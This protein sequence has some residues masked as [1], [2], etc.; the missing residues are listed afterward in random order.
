M[1]DPPFMRPFL[2]LVLCALCA[3]LLS[4]PAMPVTAQD[5]TRAT[6]LAGTDRIGTA[7]DAAAAFWPYG[8]DA[9][10]VARDDA[11]PDA[12]AGG[13]LADALDAPLL[14]TSNDRLDP[15]V[16]AAIDR[17]DPD[18][19]FLLGGTAALDP[20]VDDALEGA[21]YDTTRLA[22]ADRYAT[23]VEIDDRINSA[24][25]DAVVA[26]GER[27]P[28]ALVAMNLLPTRILLA[29]TDR[30]TTYV[31]GYRYT[32]IGGEA[33]LGSGIADLTGGVRIAGDSRYETAAEVLDTALD[34]DEPGPLFLATGASA[35]DALAASAVVARTE[36]YLVIV[37]PDRGLV[38]EQVGT[39]VANANLFTGL[40]V[41]GGP[42]ALDDAVVAEVLDVL[43][44]V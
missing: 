7:I 39:L 10:I 12:L 42:V 24:D 21:G 6:R 14:L 4:V 1:H 38:D 31:P 23:A 17:L 30:F 44:G 29:R 5:A 20:S 25:D 40:Y 41:L 26:S 19:V 28:D 32:L 22:G 8:A 3:A 2:R 15:R 9:V 11:F 37:D 34:F 36:G 43:D 18:D 35:F 27:F 16:A 33:V 13:P